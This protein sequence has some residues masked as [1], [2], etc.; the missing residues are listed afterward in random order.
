LE[1]DL[2]LV[3]FEFHSK[4]PLII[5]YGI[6]IALIIIELEFKCKLQTDNAMAVQTHRQNSLGVLD[7]RQ[8][9]TAAVNAR[10]RIGRTTN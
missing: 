10:K 3:L 4:T 6:R 5:Y 1:G 9:I 7:A 8:F 2:V